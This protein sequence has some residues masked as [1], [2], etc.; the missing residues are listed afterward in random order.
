MLNFREDATAFRAFISEHQD[1]VFNL[2][3]KLV[4]HTHDAEEI[5]QDVFVDIF[6]KPDAFRGDAAVTTWLYR[7]ATNKC[8]DHLRKQQRQ[9]RWFSASFFGAHAAETAHEPSHN[10]HPAWVT[11]NKEQ[12]A[13]L[14]KALHQLPEKQQAAWVLSEM[15]NMPYKEIGAVMNLSLSSVESLLVRARKNLKKI[16]TDMYGKGKMD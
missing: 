14:F 2:V 5:T 11:E 12:L 13:I 9:R 7:I 10:L 6:R 16:L 4:Q 3:L 8:I 15:E 1:R